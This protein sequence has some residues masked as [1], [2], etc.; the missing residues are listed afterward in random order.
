MPINKKRHIRVIGPSSHVEPDMIQGAIEWLENN[1]FEVSVASQVFTKHYQQAG[2]VQDRIEAL[3]D[4]FSDKSVDA[5]ICSCGGN[6][7]IHLLPHIDFTLIKDNPKPLFGFSD[8]TILLNAITQ[9]TGLITYH[10]LT[11]T[12]IQKPLPQEQLQQFLNILDEQLDPI[13]WDSTQALSTGNTSGTLIGGNLSVF[14]TLIGTPYFNTDRPYI[15][16]FEDVGDE[17]S[18]YDRMFAHLRVSGAFS[19]AQAILFGDFHYVDGTARIPFGK[20]MEQIIRDNTNGLSIP[21]AM[22]CPFGH[23][24]NL[25]ALPVGKIAHL[26]IDHNQVN[27]KS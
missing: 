26:L 11:M 10:G 12:K 1:N 2:T 7:A 24:D 3:H 25:W 6:G 17:I 9:K 23:R 5:I 4:A 19:N 8:I 27:I 13:T 20:N 21:I 14:Q 16:F 15:L 18:R 22:N